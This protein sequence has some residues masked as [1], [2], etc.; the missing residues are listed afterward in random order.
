MIAI[1]GMMVPIEADCLWCAALMAVYLV[2]RT[3]PQV[4]GIL[5]CGEIG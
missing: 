3:R 2:G 5:S 4:A 1:E